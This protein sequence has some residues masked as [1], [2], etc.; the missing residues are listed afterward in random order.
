[1]EGTNP[2]QELGKEIAKKD[3]QI[4]RID[5]SSLQGKITDNKYEVVSTQ[6]GCLVH[7]HFLACTNYF[8]FLL[9]T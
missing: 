8:I 1:M 2:C 5:E 7:V 6:Y 4:T 3:N 9:V